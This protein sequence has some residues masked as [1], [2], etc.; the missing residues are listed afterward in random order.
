[1]VDVDE[2]YIDFCN[3]PVKS[4]AVSLLDEFPN[5]VV[6]QTFSK[7]FSL[8]GSRCGM[9]VTSA[10]ITSVANKVKA[11]YNI[12]TLAGEVTLQAVKNIDRV[13][14]GIKQV[15]EE[16]ARVIKE[17]ETSLGVDLSLAEQVYTRIASLEVLIRN[18]TTCLHCEGCLRV[19]IGFP[20]I[21]DSFLTVFRTMMPEL[22]GATFK[23]RTI[24]AAAPQVTFSSSGCCGQY[25]H[26]VYLRGKNMRTNPLDSQVVRG[27]SSFYRLGI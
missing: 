5:L 23:G 19:T 24:V 10:D 25:V 26:G 11:P 7:A 21:N 2:A 1:M 9:L 8:A 12:S 4:S 15:I 18:R 6:I 20:E 14:A 27:Y 13:K 3:D 22:I 17:I 16:R